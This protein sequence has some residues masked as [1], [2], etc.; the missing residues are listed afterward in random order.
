MAWDKTG[1]I[2][3][4]KGDTGPAGPG[5]PTGGSF[6]Q[7]PVKLSGTDFD[8]G[9]LDSTSMLSDYYKLDGSQAL[10][11]QMDADG[12]SI[13]GLGGVF[14]T[15]DGITS[16]D[17]T[18][19]TGNPTETSMRFNA[20]GVSF[21]SYIDSVLDYAVTLGTWNF[22]NK[23]AVN[24]Q[25]LGVGT[26]APD[27]KLQVAGNIRADGIRFGNGTDLLDYYEEG[28]WTPTLKG[29]SGGEAISYSKQDGW[30]TRIGNRV[31]VGGEL[32][33]SNK[34]SSFSGRLFIGGIPFSANRF[35]SGAVG[36]FTG[37][38][39]FGYTD[40]HILGQDVRLFLYMKRTT[41]NDV[42]P[43]LHTFLTN[44]FRIMFSMNYQAA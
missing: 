22:Q 9:W 35:G 4:E 31:Q 12:E 43:L 32:Q 34:G 38:T 30:Y 8:I 1:N 26:A 41:S 11:G 14:G 25:E 16:G 44:S 18:V 10:T 17:L 21:S 33:L 15:S 36:Y 29:E 20:A 27:E 40:L 19:G 7:L 24:I 37:C 5:L 3:G 2:K 13:V 42:S 28:T 39:S 23:K 6:G